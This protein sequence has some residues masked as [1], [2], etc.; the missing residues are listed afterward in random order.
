MMIGLLVLLSAFLLVWSAYKEQARITTYR[1]NMSKSAN[2]TCWY[3]QDFERF[4][5]SCAV[6]KR[7]RSLMVVLGS[8]GHTAEMIQILRAFGQTML[9]NEDKS[10]CSLENTCQV[11]YIVA[12]SDNHSIAK[13]RCLH[14]RDGALSLFSYQTLCIPRSRYV[15][16]S[17]FSSLFTTIYSFMVSCWKL[18]WCDTPDVLICNGPGTC[19]PVVF[20]M[21]IRNVFYNLARRKSR[22]RTVF[23]ESVA[24]VRSLSLSGRILYPFVH[25]F[26]VQWP[27]MMEKYPLVEYV[28]RCL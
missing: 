28:G 14:D 4:I 18:L 6:N 16:Q 1:R 23:I 5:Q 13:A 25:R 22:T 15:G 27:D 17:Y 7:R 11:V 26:L 3:K 10:L 19:V 8:G 9:S 12:S 21:F 2:W 24:R 20:I